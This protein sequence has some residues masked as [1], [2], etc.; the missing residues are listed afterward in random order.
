MTQHSATQLGMPR[1]DMLRRAGTWN[2]NFKTSDFKSAFLYRTEGV[3]LQTEPFLLITIFDSSLGVK[4]LVKQ[5]E[6]L[7]A[8]KMKEIREFFFPVASLVSNF[9]I[10]TDCFVS[11]FHAVNR[12]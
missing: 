11:K 5:Y 7:F 9:G 6:K 2:S 8:V 3:H 12:R 4:K 10:L 1:S